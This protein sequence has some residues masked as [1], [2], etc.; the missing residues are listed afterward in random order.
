MNL[1][2]KSLT[3]GQSEPLLHAF[4]ARLFASMYTSHGFVA[5][6]SFPVYDDPYFPL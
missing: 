6:M 3:F 5:Q 1:L 2:V 4:L